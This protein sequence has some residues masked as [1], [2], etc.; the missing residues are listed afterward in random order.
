[1]PGEQLNYFK[2]K[3]LNN[4][5]KETGLFRKR[6]T[7]DGE[8]LVLN[9]VAL[10]IDSIVSF[11]AREKFIAVAVV[12]PQ[13]EVTS[14]AA[15][16]SG[17][18][19]SELKSRVD[20]ACSG[21]WAQKEKK[22]L[23][24]TGEGHRYRDGCCRHCDATVVL[25]D[26]E[27]SPQVYCG[28]CDEL[29]TTDAKPALLSAERGLKICEECGMFS[30]PKKFTIFYFYFLVVLWGFR[31]R[32][33]WR[34]P[35]CMR[36]EAWKMFFGN[37]LFVIGVPVAI[38]QLIRA[39]GGSVS[40]PFAGLDKANIKASRGEPIKAVDDYRAILKRVPNSA[41][42]KFN[43]GL[44]LLKQKTEMAA[45]SF[46]L[47]LKDCANYTPAA[48]ALAH[49]YKELG[50][51]EEL[52]ALKKKWGQEEPEPESGSQEPSALPTGEPPALPSS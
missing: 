14:I 2:F 39:Y 16:L 24:Q 31:Q 43:I 32:V 51:E 21:V 11:D 1:M 27:P 34:C 13:G 41:G 45:E 28:Y 47:A 52:K 49:C 19:A 15:A 12:T 8:T 30:R 29:S 18:A 37:L 38:A 20:A 26:M 5:G 17:M 22:E 48:N 46:K 10:P 33:T 23:E 36:G 44:G 25:T 3:W 40:G 35:A 42:I 7:F 9:D 4:E 50:Q 6:G